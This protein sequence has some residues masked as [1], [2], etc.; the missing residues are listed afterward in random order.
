MKITIELPEKLNETLD[1]FC[2]TCEA[3]LNVPTT[4]NLLN[5]EQSA[6]EKIKELKKEDPKIDDESFEKLSLPEM[7]DLI[8]K[9]EIVLNIIQTGLFAK[10]AQHVYGQKIGELAKSMHQKGFQ[11]FKNDPVQR[12][13][14]ISRIINHEWARNDVDY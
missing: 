10:C 7:E 8:N 1:L 5:E 3:I 9:G 2:K 14:F 11:G 13:I 4:I 12:Q 6:K